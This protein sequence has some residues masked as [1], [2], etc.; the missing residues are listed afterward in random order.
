MLR[1]LF[2]N[3]ELVIC[4]TIR[5]D[6]GLALSSANAL[7]GIEERHAAACVFNALTAAGEG[8]TPRFAAG[9]VHSAYE[10][11]LKEEVRSGILEDGVRPDG[12]KWSAGGRSGS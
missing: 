4:P 12:R 3:V 7:L 1:D 8:E 11:L 6:D 2:M 5:D 9:D 10:A